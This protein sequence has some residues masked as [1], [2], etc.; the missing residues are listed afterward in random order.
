MESIKTRITNVPQ[1][2]GYKTVSYDGDGTIGAAAET[3]NA[4]NSDTMKITVPAGA[5]VTDT[6]IFVHTA[7]ANSG[8][9]LITTGYP[10]KS[11]IHSTGAS[12]ASAAAVTDAFL[13][14]ANSAKVRGHISATGSG[15]AVVTGTV[16]AAGTA[17]SVLWE[18]CPYVLADDGAKEYAVHL[19]MAVASGTSGAG[20]LFW[21][22]EYIF[23]P[24]IVWAQ[25]DLA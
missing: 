12:L 16:A 6:P 2:T 8:N 7:W 19:T 22:V 5:I 21:W 14:G 13:D 11:L 4:A 24:N 10:A 15:A 1:R 17:T 9:N 23:P 25:A 3:Y 20:K 18:D